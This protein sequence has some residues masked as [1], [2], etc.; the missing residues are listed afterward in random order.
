MLTS[1]TLRTLLLA[2]L[3][4]VVGLQSAVSSDWLQFRGPNGLGFSDES[5]LPVVWNDNENLAWKTPL[6]GY[7]SSSPIAID[8]RIYLTCYSGYGTGDST[9]KLEDLRLHVVCLDQ[10]HGEILWNQTI[11]PIIK[12]C[13]TVIVSV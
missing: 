13:V 4:V 5:K 6:P 9:A 2:A 10:N 3:A 11:Q 8:G 1:S 12:V 7:G